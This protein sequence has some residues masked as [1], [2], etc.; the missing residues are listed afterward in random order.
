MQR[1]S[2][3]SKYFACVDKVNPFFVSK[4]QLF[5]TEDVISNC[6]C[7][8]RKIPHG[9]P[10][11]AIVAAI[12]PM[13]A[14]TSEPKIV[15]PRGANGPIKPVLIPLTASFETIPSFFFHGKVKTS[16]DCVEEW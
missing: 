12:D 16:D 10:A 13:I 5:P 8:P 1:Q 4:F 11:I 14:G 3:L 9:W 15:S 7:D 6:N 2:K